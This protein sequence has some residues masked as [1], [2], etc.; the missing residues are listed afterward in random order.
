MFVSVIRVD[1]A[2]ASEKLRKRASESDMA[3]KTYRLRMLG[4]HNAQCWFEAAF[5]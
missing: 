4:G 3:P 5:A 1:E 2:S